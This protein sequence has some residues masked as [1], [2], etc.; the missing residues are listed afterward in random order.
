MTPELAWKTE[1]RKISELVPYAHNPRK[2]TNEQAKQLTKSLEKFN[3]VEIPAINTDGTIIAGHQR[4]AI[5]QAL[6]RGDEVV[7]VRVPCRP[8]TE[9]EMKE[10]NLRSNKNTGEWDFEILA[11]NFDLD[12]IKDIGFSEAELGLM[13]NFTSSLDMTDLDN[14]PPTPL[15]A[16]TKPGDLWLLGDHR[17]LCADSGNPAD[18]DRLLDGAKI[19]LVNTDPPYNVNVESR[20]KNGI[21]A[22][23]A[24]EGLQHHQ[25]FDVARA[26]KKAF[27]R[28]RNMAAIRSKKTDGGV[29][30]AKD[31]PL[32]NDFVSDDKFVELLGTWFGN[33]SRVL[34]PGRSFYI[35]GGYANI[36][37]YPPALKAC[38][39]YFSQMIVWCKEWPVLT[40]K[41]FLGN[42]EWCFYGWKEGAGH[43]F[44]GPNNVTDV[45]SVK[46]VT[47]SKMVHLTEKPVELAVRAINYSSLKGENVL[48]LFGGSGS[49][50][51]ACEQTGRKAFLMEMDG[52]YCDVICKR[53]EQVTGKKA[54]LANGVTVPKD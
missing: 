53:F 23:I 30:R 4:L 32:I 46:K 27:V 41:D 6:G 54:V 15:V 47:I 16:V 18:L 49:T 50:L 45:W 7:D 26:Q 21:A 51:I 33:I 39:L 12:L 1:Q 48:D 2:L 38:E 28:G 44:Y 5:M 43:K 24:G 8:L 52:C 11:N 20:S 25:K 34:E 29:M 35:W 37:N 13:C 9:A 36:A 3:L 31:R 10:Y 40:R 22:A 42:H 14:V 19:H 17:L